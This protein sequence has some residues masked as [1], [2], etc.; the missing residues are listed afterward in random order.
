MGMRS[1]IVYASVAVSAFL[2]FC[3]QHFCHCGTQSIFCVYCT[4]YLYICDSFVFVLFSFCAFVAFSARRRR[5]TMGDQI[6]SHCW[7][8]KMQSDIVHHCGEDDIDHNNDNSEILNIDH[9]GPNKNHLWDVALCSRSQGW[10]WWILYECNTMLSWF[11]LDTHYHMLHDISIWTWLIKSWRTMINKN[12]N[13]PDM[14]L[15]SSC[16]SSNP[17]ILMVW[18]I[19]ILLLRSNNLNILHLQ[20]SGQKL[21]GI[22]GDSRSLFV[23]L[24]SFLHL[25]SAELH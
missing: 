23:C 1:F 19:L 7:P 17:Q 5:L 8:T 15:P 14:K 11:Q 4:Q 13:V 24:L 10:Q 6:H 21:I 22:A 20:R 12:A 25:P 18:G 16:L 2:Y 3:T 9:L